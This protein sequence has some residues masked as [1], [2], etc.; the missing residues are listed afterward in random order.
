MSKTKIKVVCSPSLI[1][2]G[3]MYVLD[4]K[5]LSFTGNGLFDIDD[6][7]SKLIAVGDVRDEFRIRAIIEERGD[8]L[9]LELVDDAP[10]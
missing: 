3:Q 5:N 9:G 4:T 8:E 1:P 10:A 7:P 2:P 6:E